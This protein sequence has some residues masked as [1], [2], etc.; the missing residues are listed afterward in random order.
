MDT[1]QTTITAHAA[2]NDGRTFRGVRT[3]GA[4]VYHPTLDFVRWELS[5]AELAE[6]GWGGCVTV[7]DREWCENGRT[8]RDV[9]HACV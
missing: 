5:D 9:P 3:P 1:T 2:L 7:L 6:I 4:T 8:M